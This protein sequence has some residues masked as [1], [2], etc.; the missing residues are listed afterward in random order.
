[1]KIQ[2]LISHKSVYTISAD[3][4]VKH[5]VG[6]LSTHAIGALVVSSD[7]KTIEGIVS[8]RDVVR[9]MHGSFDRLTHLLVRDIM[10]HDVHTVTPDAT[11]EEVMKLMTLERIRH[12]P[13][14][15][16]I[17]DLISIVSIGDI[18]K[19]RLQEIASDNESLLNYVTLGY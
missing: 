5:L 14:V 15:D 12:V 17:G 11:V 18:V 13:V 19:S 2:S 10:S 6:Q 7:G 16:P 8:E 4:S 1:M 3:E 9:S